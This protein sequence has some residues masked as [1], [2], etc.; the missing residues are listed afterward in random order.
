[1]QPCSLEEKHVT[2]NLLAK[3]NIEK[4]PKLCS[5]EKNDLNKIEPELIEKV[6]ELN[7][8][9]NET[10]N[11]NNKSNGQALGTKLNESLSYLLSYGSSDDESSN[12]T[13]D[14]VSNGQVEFQDLSEESMFSL[15]STDSEDLLNEAQ[16]VTIQEPSTDDKQ[17]NAK[18]SRMRDGFMDLFESSP[19]PIPTMDTLEL[20]NREVFTH[21]GNVDCILDSLVTIEALPSM[22]AYNLETLLFLEDG[23]HILGYICDVVGPVSSPLYV[24]HFA[25]KQAIENLQIQRGT[26]VYVAPKSKYTKYVFVQ[27][28]MQ[29]K[30]SDA[31]WEGDVEVPEE[32]QEFSDDEKEKE[33]RRKRG[34][35]KRKHKN[36][37][38]DRYRQYETSMNRI[39]HLKTRLHKMLDTHNPLRQ[40][41]PNHQPSGSNVTNAPV[42]APPVYV[43]SSNVPPLHPMPVNNPHVL[44]PPVDIANMY[45]P[46]RPPP[47]YPTV[48]VLPAAF[49]NLHMGG[50]MYGRAPPPPPVHMGAPQVWVQR[51]HRA[52][53]QQARYLPSGPYNQ[54]NVP[55]PSDHT[56]N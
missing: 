33:Q 51:M 22:P 42:N 9:P 44:P 16:G 7:I 48:P 45:D 13:S 56:L 4:S 43:G 40:R 53:F 46:T 32:L 1:M 19:L 2:N 37:G 26:K 3:E 14:F 20:N 47:G 24:V 34:E 41:I 5:D 39:N 10:L 52:R 18:K 17:K 30:G 11:N 49:P 6:N 50:Y 31:S 25:S 12:E 55:G 54:R 27:Q 35:T 36:E 21:I 38:Q 15:Y 8:S 28:L 29:A 23:K